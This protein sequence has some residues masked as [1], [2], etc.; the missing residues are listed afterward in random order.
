MVL[1]AKLKSII[2]FL[3]LLTSFL[4]PID[5]MAIGYEGVRSVN[6]NQE[7]STC[8]AADLK[9]D[10]L[11]TNKDLEWE[12]TNP[13]CVA[14]I[15]GVGTTVKA[16]G[17]LTK[18]MCNP[19]ND[20]GLSTV[21]TIEWPSE[22]A[23]E[24]EEPTITIKTAQGIATRTYRCGKRISEYSA[25]QT[26]C[27]ATAATNAYSCGQS[28]IALSDSIR[29]CGAVAAYTTAVGAGISAL[30][31]IY[32]VAQGS[33]NYAKI[34]GNDWYTWKEVNENGEEELGTGNW[35]R[36]KYSGS[37]SK[38]LTQLFTDENGANDCGINPNG[39]AGSKTVNGVTQTVFNKN[40]NIINKYYREYMYGGKEYEDS[41]DGKCSNPSSWNKED[42]L[43]ILGYDSD[44]QRYYMTGSGNPSVYACHRFLMKDANDASA[45]AAY[46][47]CS[48]RSQNTVCIDSRPAAE[49]GRNMQIYGGYT[50]KFCQ[51][52]GRC[53]VANVWY[54]VF[55]SQKNPEYAC[56]KTYSVCPYNHLLGG[57]TETTEYDDDRVKVK[58]YCQVMNHCAK[59]PIKPY[60]RTSDLDGAFISSACRDFIGDSQNVYDYNADLLPL[61]VRGFSAP[62]A[63][64]FKETMENLFLNKA[65]HTECANNQVPD[66]NGN[67]AS[68]NYVFKE[69]GSLDSL[70]GKSFF[71]R[72]QE[73]LQTIIKIT[74]SFSIVGLGFGVLRGMSAL[75]KTQ[76][77]SY[78]FKL[79][80]VMYF[81]VGNGWQSGFLDGVLNASNNI[82]VIVFRPDFSDD[83]AK[84]DGCQFPRFNYADQNAGTKYNNPQYPQ[85]KEY[86]QI[87]DTLDCKLARA[88]G[89]GP[90]A[91]VPNLA[92]MILGGFLTGGFG[93]IFLMA[94]L[95][96]AIFMFSIIVR[97]L[98]IFLL[99]TTAI[100]MMLYVSPITITLSLFAKTKSIFDGW[101]KQL[102][103]FVLQPVI[104]F[105]YLGI[106]LTFFD[107]VIIGN[108]NYSGSGLEAPKKIICDAEANNNSVY[109]IFNVADI[110]KFTGLELVG[111]GLPTLGSMNQAK[112]S[113]I[114]K[115]AFLLFVFLSILDKISEVAQ[116]LV[117]GAGL[118]SDWKASMT[119][120]SKASYE[121]LRGVQKR[122]M[123]AIKKAGGAAYNK[124]KSQSR[125]VGVQG[126]RKNIQTSYGNE[127][128][129]SDNDK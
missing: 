84:L 39:N 93:I 115:A 75:T 42:K 76:I 119:G 19:M 35:S 7:N 50:H 36:G 12:L 108:V 3:F 80:L 70:Y 62:M 53:N 37:Y 52:G 112:L 102:L 71:L 30:S 21:A 6:W 44:T 96:F 95:I 110:K 9:F 103:G 4:L 45:K 5:A 10:P 32:G 17:Y 41:G 69:G 85:G 88:I 125:D 28:G 55:S 90:E 46:D 117:G 15:L 129:N 72:I 106:L 18:T 98:H 13:T 56:V 111:V 57:G 121:T 73:N 109:C 11:T 89:Y 77:L 64:C 127:S 67:C 14:F 86:L 38:C 81:A 25:Y 120:I 60:I 126:D 48:K 123:G 8:D 63:Q 128:G 116:K 26:S 43:R 87:W 49:I 68:G 34:C 33:Y 61:S 51:I 107:S 66:E 23:L 114:I 40:S 24:P 27:A 92:M 113:T 122:G 58:N 31:V 2:T 54:D 104:L 101:W 99:S 97:S 118:S 22:Q 79:G 91:S 29:C 100:I 78:I 65:G 105:A 1:K 59:I 82:S 124:A 94:T 83:P 47:C 16:T 74:L 20:A